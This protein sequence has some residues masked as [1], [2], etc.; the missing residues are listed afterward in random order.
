MKK[1]YGGLAATALLTLGLGAMGAPAHAVDALDTPV[2]DY[3]DGSSTSIGIDWYNDASNDDVSGFDFTFAPAAGGTSH[4]L[5]VDIADADDEGGGEFYDDVTYAEAGIP[6]TVGASY[7]VTAVADSATSDFTDSEAS[8]PYTF[9]VRA[10]YLQTPDELTVTGSWVVGGTLTA[11]GIADPGDSDPGT[12]TPG[13]TVTY[14]WVLDPHETYSATEG[15]NE[16]VGT[17]LATTTSPSIV[18]PASAAGHVIGVSAVGTKAGYTASDPMYNVYWSLHTVADGSLRMSTPKVTGKAAVGKKL[19]VDTGTWTPGTTFSYRWLADGT[20]IK[21]KAHKSTLK[22]TKKQ[23]GA[24]ISVVV[25]GHAPSGYVSTATTG[26]VV[27]S[28]ATKK[29]K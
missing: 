10:P 14:R 26:T 2:I 12:W 8:D 28:K 6:A 15:Y 20:P 9:T 27:T 22:L 13:T 21:K 3:V 29:V 17:V 1:F 24:K 18:L 4:T 16:Y 19:K 23:K 11:A 25:T 5:H 7:T